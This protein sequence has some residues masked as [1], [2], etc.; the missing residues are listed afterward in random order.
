[1]KTKRVELTDDGEFW[2]R[3]GSNG[4]DFSFSESLLCENIT[5]FYVQCHIFVATAAV[6]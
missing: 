5:F 1:M 4:E 6:K 2:G 3:G